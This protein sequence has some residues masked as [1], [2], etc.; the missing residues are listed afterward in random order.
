MCKHL[1]LT[2]SRDI[3]RITF[4]LRSEGWSKIHFILFCKIH[5]RGPCYSE[6]LWKWLCSYVMLLLIFCITHFHHHD[7][8]TINCSS[9]PRLLTRFHSKS[10]AW[11][12][13]MVHSEHKTVKNYWGGRGISGYK[14]R[15][16]QTQLMKLQSEHKILIVYCVK[17]K[18]AWN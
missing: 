2:H 10:V 14:T 12:H 18:R 4:L 13:F 8:P 7:L 1:L 9:L 15:V 3:T 11:T 6:H 5:F 16:W 17:K